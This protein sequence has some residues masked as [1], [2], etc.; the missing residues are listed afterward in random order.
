MQEVFAIGATFFLQTPVDRQQ[1]SILFRTV[2]GGMLENR[3]RSTRVS[4]QTDV[5]CEV[6]SRTI[7]GV[8]RRGVSILSFTQQAFELDIPECARTQTLTGAE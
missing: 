6:G 1:L 5:I 3:R 8:I 2:R 4:I 7:R